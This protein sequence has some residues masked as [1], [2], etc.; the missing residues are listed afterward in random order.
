MNTLDIIKFGHLTM[1]D[2]LEK[3]NFSDWET[4]GVCGIWN[5]KDIVAHLASY[6]LWHVEVLN[7]ILGISAR[8]P[9]MDSR[10][11]N[12]D[13]FNDVEVEKRQDMTPQDVFDAYR[14]GQSQVISLARKVPPSRFTENGTLPWYGEEYSLNDFLVYT[15]YGHKREHSAQVNA[16]RDQLGN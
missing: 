2:A 10:A 7:D 12:G 9:I 3:V 8:T 11:E 5:V 14:S 16:Y 15:S 1:I 13:L 4:P 6:E